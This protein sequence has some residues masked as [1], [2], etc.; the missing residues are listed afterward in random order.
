MHK[1]ID[2]ESA[3]VAPPSVLIFMVFKNDII[4]ETC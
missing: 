4:C 2:I 1:H 3:L